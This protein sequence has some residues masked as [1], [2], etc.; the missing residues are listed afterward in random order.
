[1]LSN[2]QSRWIKVLLE[3]IRVHWK[4]V[5]SVAPVSPPGRSLVHRPRGLLSPTAIFA[6]A[7]SGSPTRCCRMDQIPGSLF[8]VDLPCMC[9]YWTIIKCAWMCLK[10]KRLFKKHFKKPV[11]YN[12]IQLC[13]NTCNIFII[14][15]Q[16]YFF[17]LKTGKLEAVRL[18]CSN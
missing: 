12:V 7:G 8:P 1:M 9:E 11:N 10:F 3:S 13:N 6:E 2:S 4:E 18:Q 17:C 15:Q 5:C 14:C 16:L